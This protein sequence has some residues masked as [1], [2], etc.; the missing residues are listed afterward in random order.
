MAEPS[1]SSWRFLVGLGNPGRKYRDTRHNVGFGVLDELVRRWCLD[2]GRAAFDGRFWDTQIDAGDEARVRVGLL[3][4]MTY[5]N[6]S[7]QAVRQL[8]Q[9]YKAT[10]AELLVIYDDVALET[11]R[12]RIRPGGSAAGHNGLDDILRACGTNDVPRLRI[13]IGQ[14]PGRMER[15]DYVLGTFRDEEIELIAPAI[16]RAADAAERWL[17]DDMQ[18]VMESTNAPC[19]Q[20]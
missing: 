2:D 6:N 13:G 4:P 7:G 16:V 1:A 19:D 20:G 8:L 14:P 15:K 11:G 9:F 5:M 18:S 12:L 17:T 10:P 3:A